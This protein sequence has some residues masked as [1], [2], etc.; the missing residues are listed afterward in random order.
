MN[1]NETIENIQT[2]LKNIDEEIKQQL[3][4]IQMNRDSVANLNNKRQILFECLNK[5]EKKK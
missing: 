4:Y 1:K 2:W 3:L 5:L